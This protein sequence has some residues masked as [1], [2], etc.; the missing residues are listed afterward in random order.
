MAGDQKGKLTKKERL[1]LEQENQILEEWLQVLKDMEK[2][3]K[4]TSRARPSFE[5]KN[6]EA[7]TT[8]S[9][10]KV[11]EPDSATSFQEAQTETSLVKGEFEKGQE[12]SLFL[13]QSEFNFNNSF[14]ELTCLE[15][16]LP[17]KVV[18]VSQ[19]AKEDSAEKEP[20]QATQGEEL[21][22]L[23]ILQ[24]KTAPESLYYDL[25]EHCKKANMVVSV[26]QM[27]VKASTEEIKRFGLDK[28]KDFCVSKSVFDNM[29]KSLK[30][31]KP[32]NLF[33]QKCFQ[34][35]NKNIS[36]HILSLHHFL[37][38]S[39][40][41][42]HNENV[43]ELQLKQSDFCFRKPCD[44][45]ART[46]EK[47]FVLKFPMHELLTDDFLASNYVLK[48]PR[49]FHKP[50]LHHADI[51]F[52]FVKS[53]NIFE[54]EIDCLCAENDFK[55]VGL[56]FE[57]ILVY[58]TFFDKPAGQLKL[59]FIDSECVNLFLTDIWVCNI[60]FDKQN[61]WRNHIVLCFGDILVYNTFFDMI[62]HL[63]CPKEVEKGTGEKMVYKYQSI[64]DESLAKLEMQQENFESCLAARFDIGAVRGSYLNN[65]KE[66]FNKLDC[67]G[68][69]THEGLTSNWNHDQIFSGERVMD[70]TSRM[71]LCVLCLNFS[72]FKISQSY[73][74]RPGEHP[75]VIDHVFRNSFIYYTDMMHLFLSKEPC[76]D[77]KKAWKQSRRKNKHEED[78]RFKPPDLDQE[79][80]PDVLALII[81]KE[82]PP[83][84]EYKPEPNR[85][86]F[87]IRL[88][89][90]DKFLC[91]NLFCF[92]ASGVRR[93][94]WIS[95]SSISE[96]NSN[97][98][99][100]RGLQGKCNL[101]SNFYVADLVPFI[102]GKADLM[103]NLFEEGGDDMIMESTKEWKHEPE[104]EELVAEDAT[105][106]NAWKQEEYIGLGRSLII[107]DTLTII[108]ATPP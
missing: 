15:P 45:F 40:S 22:Q 5:A 108:Q 72:E 85:N 83:D 48:E 30:E 20:E 87:G 70:S 107:Q 76:A 27:F 31:F 65:H 52:E 18:S 39:Q 2:Q 96:S 101:I 93:A 95:V 33:D 10:L 98:A 74:W 77:Y 90:F 89:L 69:L 62:T 1:L 94:N 79:K 91:A 53:E 58:N 8:V 56:F 63:T 12:F 81:I 75:K 23:N 38:H 28:V 104:P 29:F 78:K 32:E 86:K 105:L 99:Y 36:G 55:R 64:K 41:F 37:K 66:L 43:L 67:Y 73:L 35:N 71:I 61:R 25:Q 46:E 17:S 7:V 84:A 13:P 3:P 6:Q 47:M 49:K 34:T 59:E 14:D 9:E 54:F 82:A 19:V 68:N 106:K 26:P 44:S 80:Y 103:S 4:R 92:I 57:D 88:L 24:S 102:A 16:V 60:L 21:E 42:N 100:L 11:A 51:R 97:N 50:K